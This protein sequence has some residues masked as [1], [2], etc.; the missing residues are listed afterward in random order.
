MLEQPE[1]HRQKTFNQEYFEFL[2]FFGGD[3][4][5]NICVKCMIDR[6]PRRSWQK[7]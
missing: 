5:I 1:T 2:K 4:A 7:R 6:S 3:T